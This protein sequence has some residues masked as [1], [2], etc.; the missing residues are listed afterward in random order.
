MINNVTNYEKSICFCFIIFPSFL[1]LF[2]YSI[3]K[4]HKHTEF[5]FTN[6]VMHVE[7]R[8]INVNQSFIITQINLVKNQF[9][10]RSIYLIYDK[11]IS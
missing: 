4:F 7:Y 1:T 10:I 2:S 3:T 5:S 9:Y 6:V 11:K 8:L